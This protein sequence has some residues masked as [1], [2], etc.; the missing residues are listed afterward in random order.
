MWTS[1]KKSLQHG[2]HLRSVKMGE[3][4]SVTKL[5]ATVFFIF[6]LKKI[7]FFT[8]FFNLTLKAI[9]SL[10]LYYIHPLDVMRPGHI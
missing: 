4:D 1:L 5:E 10:L 8:V 9:P 7:F 6:S 2:G 3:G